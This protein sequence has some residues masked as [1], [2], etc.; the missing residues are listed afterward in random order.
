MTSIQSVSVE[1]L[2]FAALAGGCAFSLA[3]SS[4]CEANRSVTPMK[5][6]PGPP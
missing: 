1:G 5:G 4:F 3:G 2:G 6:V